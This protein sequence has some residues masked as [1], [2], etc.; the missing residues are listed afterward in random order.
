[1][2]CKR[3]QPALFVSQFIREYVLIDLAFQRDFVLP[4]KA[5]PVN[6]EEGM[7]FRIKGSL[8]FENPEL[9]TTEKKVQTYVFGQ[10]LYR[11]NL[12]ISHE[13]MIVH[14]RFQPGGLFRLLRI[15]M[16]ELAHKSVEASL[17]FG[18]EIET[19]ND[20]LA[21]APDYEHIPEILDGFFTSQFKKVKP[22]FQPIDKIGQLIQ[23]N[24]QG[25]HLSKMA[26][27]ACLSLRQF[28]KRF[29]QQIGIPP[30]HFARICRFYQAW[31]QKEQQ[32][33][34]DWFSIAVLNGY[35]DYQH[36]VKDFKQFAGT[37]PNSLID[38]STR[39]PER[40]LNINPDFIG[41]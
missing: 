27:A 28:E 14:I 41:V 8:S 34:L 19:V 29:V 17:I 9:N 32:P 30:K 1:M 39:N 16:D 4:V 21:N 25:F 38:E 5:Y 10:P 31:V 36:L 18:S 7:T 40:R 24:P 13:F 37:T 11:Q 33:G 12:H 20:R 23:A 2:I 6:P 35:S 15:P 22:G 3:I 26:D